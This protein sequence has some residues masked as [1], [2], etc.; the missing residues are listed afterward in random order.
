MNSSRGLLVV[1]ALLSLL[2]ASNSLAAE[3][4][5]FLYSQYFNAPGENRYP[6][7]GN[8]SQAMDAL[9]KEFTV[10]TNAEPLNAQTLAD[11]KVLLIANPNDCG[12]T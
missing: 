6:A 10:R 3:K 5:V 9:R 7:G 4:P 1:S 8:Y 2:V 12:I 11:V